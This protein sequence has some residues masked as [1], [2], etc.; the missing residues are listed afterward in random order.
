MEDLILRSSLAFYR[1]MKVRYDFVL[2]RAGRTASFS[3]N[4]EDSDCVHLLGLQYL[5]DRQ[6]FKGAGM[7]FKMILNSQERRSYF[8]SS[9]FW[10]DELAARVRCVENLEA[11]LDSHALVFRYCE[12]N[13][14]FGSKIQAEYLLDF[15]HPVIGIQ[16]FGE[17]YLFLDKRTG[18]SERFCRSIFPRHDFRDYTKGQTKWTLLYERKVNLSSGSELVVYQHRLYKPETDVLH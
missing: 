15:V 8:A 10:S 6:D 1:L 18:R 7:I 11:L 3:L 16:E 9:A 14:R 12:R 13:S 4:F 2:G 17:I 5:A